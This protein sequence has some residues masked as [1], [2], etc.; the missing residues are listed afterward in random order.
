MNAHVSGESTLRVSDVS[1]HVDQRALGANNVAGVARDGVVQDGSRGAEHVDGRACEVAA[2]HLRIAGPRIVGNR[3][4]GEV[5]ASGRGRRYLPA[6]VLIVVLTNENGF[7]R[8]VLDGVV[9]GH[10]IGGAVNPQAVP[11]ADGTDGVAVK[12]DH[13]TADADT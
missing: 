3:V 8:R 9:L 10:H 7:L 6:L 11:A 4:V 12:F 2:V 1:L 13:R 5:N